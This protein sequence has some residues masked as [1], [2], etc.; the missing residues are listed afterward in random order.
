MCNVL[1]SKLSEKHIDYTEENSV[2]KM[3]NMGITSVPIL[4]ADG[5]LLSFKEAVEWVNKQQGEN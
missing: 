5:L 2:E 3:M 1:K 4:C